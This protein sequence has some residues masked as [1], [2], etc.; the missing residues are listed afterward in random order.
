MSPYFDQLGAPGGCCRYG[1]RHLLGFP[2]PYPIALAGIGPAKLPTIA[3][4]AGAEI[5]V[6]G[7]SRRAGPPPRLTAFA[8][9]G[10]VGGLKF[11]AN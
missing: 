2:L 11:L 4:D 1:Y 3:F 7:W 8:L 10:L 5:I 6:K 9:S